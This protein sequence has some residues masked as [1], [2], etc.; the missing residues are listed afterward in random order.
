IRSTTF[1]RHLRHRKRHG[2][3][4]WRKM[5]HNFCFPRSGQRIILLISLKN[6]QSSVKN[7]IPAYFKHT[8]K[9]ISSGG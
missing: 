9:P 4:G 3:A 1:Y 7:N 5:K 8:D 2:Y 6:V